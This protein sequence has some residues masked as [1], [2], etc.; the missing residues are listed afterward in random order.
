M[1]VT[2][3][4]AIKLK[5]SKDPPNNKYFPVSCYSW[6][7]RE[8]TM[9]FFGNLSLPRTGGAVVNMDDHRFAIIGGQVPGKFIES[10]MFDIY[11]DSKFTL[12][13]SSLPERALGPCIASM[14]GI[15]YAYLVAK[16]NP[17]SHP[18]FAQIEK[19]TLK[20]RIIPQPPK[21]VIDY[22]CSFVCLSDLTPVVVLS[23]VAPKDPDSLSLQIFNTNI[24]TWTVNTNL[25]M[26]TFNEKIKSTFQPLVHK[27]NLLLFINGHSKI[28]QV[29]FEGNILSQAGEEYSSLGKIVFETSPMYISKEMGEAICSNKDRKINKKKK[30]SKKEK[31]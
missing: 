12:K 8:K 30:S 16:E 22:Y 9:K 7:G 17:E 15:E 13:T 25:K 31:G 23:S 10:S 1:I 21:Y 29:D 11:Q 4:G 14:P 27:T 2:C 19:A 24:G 5:K 6:Q 18:F 3:G 28:Y 20:S 26:P